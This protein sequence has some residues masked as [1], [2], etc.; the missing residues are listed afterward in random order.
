[1]SI[2]Y[3]QMAKDFWAD[4]IAFAE[5]ACFTCGGSGC[6][7]INSLN[8]ETGQWTAYVPKHDYKIFIDKD[9]KWTS[10]KEFNDISQPPEK[11]FWSQVASLYPS[12]PTWMLEAYVG[13]DVNDYQILDDDEY[14]AAVWAASMNEHGELN[15][16]YFDVNA[17]LERLYDTTLLIQ[18]EDEDEDKTSYSVWGY[19]ETHET[20]YSP[21]TS[22][23]EVAEPAKE[24]YISPF[25][26]KLT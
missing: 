10:T 17:R 21:I 11:F 14:L 5:T 9:G 15:D 7:I 20:D 24:T 3:T 16:E 12:I 6:E 26:G 1:M 23:D 22:W 25:T 2:L 18:H 13:V 19:D 4:E 8:E